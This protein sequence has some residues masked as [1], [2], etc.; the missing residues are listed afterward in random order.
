MHVGI[1]DI[2][3][4]PLK[5][6]KPRTQRQLAHLPTAMRAKKLSMLEQKRATLN[7]TAK[8]SAQPTVYKPPA[9]PLAQT[10][11]TVET[12]H[13]QPTSSHSSAITSTNCTL[14]ER[15]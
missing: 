1:S 11:Q 5:A 8:P 2:T 15:R 13:S 10:V 9:Q 4:Q 12:S 6:K 3:A 14:K 7:A